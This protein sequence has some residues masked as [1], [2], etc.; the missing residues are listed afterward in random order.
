[1]LDREQRKRLPGLLDEAV[2][3][4]EAER[5]AFLDRVGAD[6]AE[7]RAELESLIGHAGDDTFLQEPLARAK[8]PETG[9]STGAMATPDRIGDVDVTR[10]LGVGGMG[11]VYVGTRSD[12]VRVAAKVIRTEMATEALLRRFALEQ[13]VLR[14]LDHP[15]VARILDVGRTELGLPYFTMEFVDGPSILRFVR[16]RELGL[17][18]RLELVLQACAGVEH[19]HAM[20]VLHRD[21]H[22][23]NILV[24]T[25]ARPPI[26]KVIDFGLAR[27]DGLMPIDPRTG[28]VRRQTPY[29]AVLGTRG[30]MSPEQESGDTDA[31]DERTDVYGLA[32]TLHQ[33]V[34]G[35]LPAQA[36]GDDVAV[37]SV[38]GCFAANAMRAK[39][40]RTQRKEVRTLRAA[41]ERGLD[42]PLARALALRPL[43]RQP[44]V[45][46]FADAVHAFVE[47]LADLPDG[48]PVPSPRP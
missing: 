14:R 41:L 13:D 33:L 9:W 22:P 8:P 4:P 31:I 5:G 29:G 19:A 17:A 20:G 2:A 34:C 32:R 42:D 39:M 21:L 48:P 6:S 45:S 7:L 3:L 10:C 36:S 46:L 40:S 11:S 24:D 30:Y 16:D 12:G 25:T 15:N 44:S 35:E 47:S 26:V 27:C 28:E 1:M 37:R 18:R 23:S 43:D 38:S